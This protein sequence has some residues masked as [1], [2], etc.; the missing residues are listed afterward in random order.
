MI[1][2]N[3]VFKYI[4]TNETIRIIEVIDEYVY[5]VNVYGA[6]AM[7]AKEALE[8]LLQD[9]EA[10][11]LIKVKEPYSRIIDEKDLSELQIS[12]RDEDWIII[13]NYWNNYKLELLEKKS[14]VKKFEEIAKA[15][16]ISVPKVKKM[17]SRFWQRGMNKNA[18]LPDYMNS[19]GRG[20]ERDLSGVKVGRP[21]KT[22]YYGEKVEGINITDEVKKHF[23]IVIN[24]YYRNNNKISLKETYNFML[25]D[26]YSD[27]YK[28]G[29]E[30]KH[31][32]WDS[33]RTPTYDQFYY[34]FR[35]SED[36][37][38]DIRFREGDKAFELGNRS[39]LSNSTTETDGP[40]TRFQIDATVADIYIVSSLN[41]NRIIG[42]PVVYA[43]IDVFSRLVTG[44][45][46]GLEGPSW[47]GAMMALDNMLEDKVD[48]CKR[49][50]TIYQK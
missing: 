4:D 40:G 18:L 25:R 14:R 26:F 10:D 50:D 8:I 9:I 17:F 47:I 19:G 38:K 48:F 21:K 16:Q 12:K 42:R 15:S 7:P 11:K 23:E 41:R 2:V 13:D 29:N 43:I 33:D 37:Q 22:N 46:V 30:I 6:T 20:V 3:S 24:K 39:L 27:I 49:Y 32:V 44:I 1:A 34:W 28:Q 45:Y 31:R 5:L 35:K 36:V